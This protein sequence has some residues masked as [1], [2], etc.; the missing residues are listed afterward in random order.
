MFSSR[1]AR[2]GDDEF[3]GGRGGGRV[4]CRICGCVVRPARFGVADVC[5]RARCQRRYL[6]RFGE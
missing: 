2:R 5:S 4:H 3:G 1:K 6:D